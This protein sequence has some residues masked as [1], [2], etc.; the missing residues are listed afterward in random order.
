MQK[1]DRN[2]TRIFSEINLFLQKKYREKLQKLQK[3]VFLFLKKNE[4][5]FY[6]GLANKP[7]FTLSLVNPGASTNDLCCKTIPTLVDQIIRWQ[8]HIRA[9]ITL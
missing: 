7:K 4:R 9:C 2:H 1:L 3:Y 8:K 5:T 6:I